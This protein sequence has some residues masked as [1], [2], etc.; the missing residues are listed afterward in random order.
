MVGFSLGI[1]KVIVMNR[2]IKVKNEEI[3]FDTNKHLY[4]INEDIVI[5]YHGIRK[6]SNKH[7]NKI[8]TLTIEEIDIEQQNRALQ[9]TN[10]LEKIK[11]LQDRSCS[12][13]LKHRI[14]H[15]SLVVLKKSYA[16]D[17]VYCS[18]GSLIG[19]MVQSGFD[20]FLEEYPNSKDLSLNCCFNYSKKSYNKLIRELENSQK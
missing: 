3:M 4:I 8:S 9:F 12:Y 2:V 19:A 15:Y 14:E 7:Y 16:D 13:G 18:N 10:Q 20:L 6:K 1:L 11:G 17:S 5:D